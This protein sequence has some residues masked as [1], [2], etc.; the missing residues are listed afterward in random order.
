MQKK[1]IKNIIIIFIIIF[2]LELTI[3]NINSY[4]IISSKN[5]KTFK[6]EDF[7]YLESDGGVTLIELSDLNTEVKTI[8]IEVENYKNIK[9]QLLYTDET[10]SNYMEVPSKTYIDTLRNS[11]YMPVYLSGI[12]DKITIRLYGE[13]A[14]ISLVTI[15]E[16]IPINF[17]IARLLTLFGIVTFIYC[18]KNLEIFNKPFS[19]KNIKQEFILIAVLGVFLWIICF[20]N[21]YSKETGNY[22]FYCKDFV[23]SISEGKIYL[24]NEPTENL[25]N[26]ENPYDTKR[27]RRC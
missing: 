1:D 18:L 22:D 12:S 27:K 7:T 3:F 13:E 4:R 23:K 11:K 10:T 2:I 6:T 5:S 19:E 14:E 16:R 17:S 26:M 9:Y 21:G 20:I 25:L 24:Q 15:N 8:H